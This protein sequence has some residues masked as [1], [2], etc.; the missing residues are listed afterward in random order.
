MDLKALDWFKHWLERVST[1]VI[2]CEKVY[3]CTL[4]EKGEN[5]NANK[6]SDR[7]RQT[8]PRVV[9]GGTVVDNLVLLRLVSD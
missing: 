8:I 2:P 1:I 6:D 4:R 9:D 5:Q 7:G 3:K